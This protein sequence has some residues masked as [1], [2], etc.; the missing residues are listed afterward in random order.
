[1]AFFGQSIYFWLPGVLSWVTTYPINIVGLLY[2]TAVLED[3]TQ[4]GMQQVRYIAQLQINI[5]VFSLYNLLRMCSM[6]WDNVQWQHD[7]QFFV[8]FWV[9]QRAL[10]N[11]GAWEISGAA[12]T[13]ITRTYRSRETRNCHHW[14]MGALDSEKRESSK[15][16]KRAQI[17]KNLLLLAY[18]AQRRYYRQ[19]R[20]HKLPYCT[21]P[22]CS[23]FAAY[24][25]PGRPTLF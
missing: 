17:I 12:T 11:W 2:Y 23:I 9:R 16:R 1:M 5:I 3:S 10:L 24:R 8:R 25:H 15:R 20:R 4:V 21:R 7:G 22:S 19:P 6:S 13:P 14:F 18:S